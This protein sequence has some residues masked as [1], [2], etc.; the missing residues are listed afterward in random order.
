MRFEPYR[1]VEAE[2]TWQCAEVAAAVQLAQSVF[3]GFLHLLPLFLRQA[4][5]GR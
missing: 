3:D 2:L 4:K 1:N 5:V